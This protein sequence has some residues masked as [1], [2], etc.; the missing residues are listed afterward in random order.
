MN[1]KKRCAIRSQGVRAVSLALAGSLL[2]ACDGPVPVADAQTSSG[3]NGPAYVSALGRIEPLNGVLRISAS[4]MPDAMSGGIL[5]ELK[6]DTGD[7]VKAGDLLAITDTA[8]VL[9]ARLAESK[10]LLGL[11]RQ[12]ATASISSAD[13]TCVRAGVLKRDAERLSALRSQNLASE[14]ESDRASGAAQAADA[15]CVADRI[16][17]QVAQANILVAEARVARHEKELERAY[18]YAPVDGRVLSVNAREGERIDED[19][20]LELGR[21]DEMY[22]IAE[23]YEADVARLSVGQ[24]AK[25]TSRALKSDL[26]GRIKRIRP[27]VRKQ[28]QIGTDPAARKDARVVEVEVILDTP[29]DAAGYTNLQVDVRFEP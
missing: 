2:V 10:S 11:V 9:E 7:D 27:L 14:D 16:A 29:D 23:V 15:D 1:N 13:A 19:G 3:D 21:V 8:A 6:V 26:A 12:Q 17:A 28:D 20:I 24:T 18:I 5:V 22:A 4:S 25:V